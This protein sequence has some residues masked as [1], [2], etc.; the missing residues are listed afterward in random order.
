MH[1]STGLKRGLRWS[2]IGLLGLVL[3]GGLSSVNNDQSSAPAQVVQAATQAQYVTLTSSYPVW[4][5]TSL[6]Q[7]VATSSVA[8]HTYLVAGTYQ[9]AKTG[10]TYYVLNNAAG[11]TIGYINSKGAK[12]TTASQ[13]SWQS[14]SGYATL[15]QSNAVVY[16][17]FAG[18]TRSTTG[19]VGKTYH[20]TGLYETFAGNVYYS[21]Y[22]Q[23][24]KWIGYMLS[25]QFAQSSQPQGVWQAYNATAKVTKSYP[26]WANFKWQES[27]KSN[28]FTT[29]T[30]KGKYSHA[31]G[32]TYYSVYAPS[33]S[34]LGYL[35][36]NAVSISTPAATT[37]KAQNYGHYITVTHQYNTWANFKWQTKLS[38]AAVNSRTYWAKYQYKNAN[39]ST[40]LSLYDHNNKWAGYINRNG[41]SV[42]SGAQGTW[43]N[44]TTIV[45]VNSPNYSIYR[46]FK[47]TKR[48]LTKQFT[49]KTLT[50]KGEYW[51]YNGSLYYSLYNG[52]QWL[53]YVNANAMTVK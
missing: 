45:A 37:S 13:G 10:S 51:H 34:W 6:T 18:A 5:S 28:W 53:G 14:A 47:W 21:L 4:T 25:G 40:Y 2:S 27:A 24:N 48:Y 42:A 52:S 26:I 20:I 35:N 30:I 31:N 3:A 41:V 32:S 29:L 50:A 9:S 8:H 1:L 39:G 12:L 19:L 22:D 46:D 49:G 43:Q 44:V 17:N 33:G 23:N 16:T 11:E 7:Q 15:T 36:A 38:A